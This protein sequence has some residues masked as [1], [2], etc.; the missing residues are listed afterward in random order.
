MKLKWEV[1]SSQNE[2]AAKGLEDI[3]VLYLFNDIPEAKEEKEVIAA[4]VK[5]SKGEWILAVE[6]RMKQNRIVKAKNFEEAE[7]LLEHHMIDI[8]QEEIDA[9][10]KLVDEVKRMN[11]LRNDN[12]KGDTDDN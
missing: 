12:T 10:Q 8:M 7:S 1:P 9:R 6:G 4:V 5:K 11:S 3:H 2:N